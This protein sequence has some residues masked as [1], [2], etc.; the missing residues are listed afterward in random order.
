[1]FLKSAILVFSIKNT[2]P[3]QAGRGSL[4]EAGWDG[5][6]CGVWEAGVAAPA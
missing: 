5:V 3:A 2:Y 6:W 4:M 1:M